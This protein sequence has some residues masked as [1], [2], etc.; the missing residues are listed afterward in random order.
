MKRKLSKQSTYK[1]I[2]SKQFT[3]KNSFRKNISKLIFFYKQYITKN[4]TKIFL[5]NKKKT[6][7]FHFNFQKN[8]TKRSRLSVG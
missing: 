4:F 2:F 8:R 3:E 7:N 6:I 1:K 5:E